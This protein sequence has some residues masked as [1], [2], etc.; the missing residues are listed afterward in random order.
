M[1]LN[2]AVQATAQRE[3][4]ALLS[5]HPEDGQGPDRLPTYEDRARLPYIDAVMKEVLRWMPVAPMGLPHVT[6]EEDVFRGWYI[7]K[8]A[9][10]LA[11]IW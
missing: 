5:T 3:L 1:M 9:L 6:T 10:L 8:G 2:P 7:P 4:D 11:N